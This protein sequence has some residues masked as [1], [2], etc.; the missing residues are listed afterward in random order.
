MPAASGAGVLGFKCF[1]ACGG[2]VSRDVNVTILRLLRAPRIFRPAPP[3]YHRGPTPAGLPPRAYPRGPTPAGLPLRC[4]APP[5]PI[6]VAPA[7]RFPL[8]R[9]RLSSPA[10]RADRP[11]SASD[12]SSTSA[13]QALL[14]VPPDEG[15]LRF[16]HDGTSVKQR[17]RQSARTLAC[18]RA[19]ASVWLCRSALALGC[20]R[21]RVR[22]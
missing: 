9:S 19:C 8:L 21:V 22:A 15:P 13:V 5:R 16:H 3:P 17:T 14:R 6:C 10:D 4:P 2:G 11:L 18:V 7:V 12:S 20:A 1:G